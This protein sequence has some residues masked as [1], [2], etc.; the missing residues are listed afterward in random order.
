MKRISFI[1]WQLLGF[2]VLHMLVPMVESAS[3]CYFAT[4]TDFT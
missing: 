4:N 2:L 1:Y 3:A